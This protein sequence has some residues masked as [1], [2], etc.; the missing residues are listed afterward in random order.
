MHDRHN[1]RVAALRFATVLVAGGAIIFLLW[2]F[3]QIDA[4]TARMMMPPVEVQ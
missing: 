1:R 3:F 4:S 2:S